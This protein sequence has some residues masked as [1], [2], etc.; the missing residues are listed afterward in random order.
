MTVGVGNDPGEGDGVGAGDG[1]GAGT[2]GG[3]GVG[4]GTGVGVGA[5]TVFCI[6]HVRG[7]IA[8]ISCPLLPAGAFQALMRMVMGPF[9]SRRVSKDA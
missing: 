7:G 4:D 9:G 6:V 8:M 3:A 2:G 1:T 5:E